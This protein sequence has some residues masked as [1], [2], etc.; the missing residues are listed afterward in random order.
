M[1]RF[2]VCAVIVFAVFREFLFRVVCF[3]VKTPLHPTKGVNEQVKYPVRLEF[4]YPSRG[5]LFDE[6][7]GVI[8]RFFTLAV[9]IGNVALTNP[10]SEKHGFTTRFGRDVTEGVNVPFF[11][12]EDEIK[13]TA[14]L[15]GK[16]L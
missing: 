12:H 14:K 15:W 10:L 2:D 16:L 11:H 3:R 4:F 13:L 5:R 8:K 1:V 7:V 9:R 6:R